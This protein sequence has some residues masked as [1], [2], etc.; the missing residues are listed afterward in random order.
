LG[1]VKPGDELL[2]RMSTGPAY[3][4][5]YADTVR[6]SPQASEIFRQT[7][8]LLTLVL[9]DDET[10]QTRI[11]L[12][13]VYL[14]ESELG[15]LISTTDQPTAALGERVILNDELIVTAL[16]V[17][18]VPG[19]DSPPGYVE[20]ALDF[21]LENQSGQDFLSDSF[22]H[23]IETEGLSYAAVSS[24]TRAGHYPPLPASIRP[25]KV[26]TA[27][28]SYLVPETVA[29]SGSIWRFAP[30]TAGSDVAQIR[31][32]PFTEALKTGVTV[33]S[34]QMQP[35]GDILLSVEL[36]AA[37]RDITINASDISVQGMRIAPTG[38]RF[39]WT[40]AAGQTGSFPLQ[41]EVMSNEAMQV[42][43]HGQAFTLAV[44]P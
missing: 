17:Y 26:I 5:A 9:L 3:R 10:E 35:G 13:A 8:P 20:L 16:D 7:Q 12:R 28:A 18:P 23:Q 21:V 4:F 41:L 27:T 15:L 29:Q 32:A 37:S 24:L 1:A 44:G 40:L 36:S 31:L 25:N 38:N 34:A 42:T 19:S 14:P 33:L 22:R 39:P 2:L 6:V 11:V 30:L 43:I